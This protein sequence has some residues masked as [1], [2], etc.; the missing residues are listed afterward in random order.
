MLNARNA[1]IN[2]LDKGRNGVFEAP[3]PSIASQDENQPPGQSQFPSPAATPPLQERI[4]QNRRALSH[5]PQPATSTPGSVSS[6]S[7]Y[8]G[9]SVAQLRGGHVQ[10]PASYAMPAKSSAQAPPNIPGAASGNGESGHSSNSDICFV[11]LTLTADE[12]KIALRKELDESRRNRSLSSSL[13]QA[14]A[15]DEGQPSFQIH[16]LLKDAEPEILESS[17][18]QGVRLLQRLRK[19]LESKAPDSSDAM[20]WV[21]QI[22]T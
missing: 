1:A 13:S 11:M 15:Q 8:K 17:V 5:G 10:S 2:F 19:P 9:S 22:G 7:I 6:P 4:D 20:Q 18:D 3:R 21:Q 12:A 16:H 14:S